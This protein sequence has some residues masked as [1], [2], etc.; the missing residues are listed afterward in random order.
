MRKVLPLVS[1]AKAY[2]R[3]QQ[4]GNKI[5]DEGTKEYMSHNPDL[6]LGEV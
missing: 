6:C 5:W 4:L 3:A 1:L 2:G